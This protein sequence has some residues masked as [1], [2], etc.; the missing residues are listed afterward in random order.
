MT[1]KVDPRVKATNILRRDFEQYC[2]TVLKIKT[3]SAKLVPFVWNRAQKK[4]AVYLMHCLRNGIP[5]RC[6]IL[7]ARQLGF[8]T[9]IAAFFYWLSS[10]N[11]HRG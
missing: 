10:M 3:K 1:T 2:S 4:F 9:L 6:I 8:S 11:P 5:I 7:K